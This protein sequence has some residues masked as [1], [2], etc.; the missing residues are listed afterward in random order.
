MATPAI[1]VEH[2]S[3]VFRVW[4]HP[5]DML[6]EMLTGRRR[7]Q[8]FEA[9]KD[10]S[11]EVGRGEIVGIMGRNGAG[12]STMLRIIAG[13]LDATH[14]KA[15]VVGRISAILELGTGFHGEY[16][17]R[18]NIQLGG[19][20]LGLSASEIAAKEAEIIAF[21]ELAEFIDRPFKTYSSGMQARLTFA[22]ATSID[23]DIFI[24]DEAL[25]V[26]D[27]KFQR[28]CFARFEDF[29]A[30]GRTILFVT[31]ATHLVEQICDRAI[32]LERG[33][34]KL[35]GSPKEVTDTYSQDLFGPPDGTGITALSS[36]ADATGPRYG[37]GGVE[38]FDI[39]LCDDEGRTIRVVPSGAWCIV[40]C[41]ARCHQGLVDDLNIGVSITTTEGV[42]LFAI[43]PQLNRQRTPAL[44]KDDVL[45]V[46]VRLQM[47]LGIGNYFITTGAWGFMQEHHYDRRVDVVHFRIS[48][49]S[50][51]SQ[52]LVNCFP[53][54]DMS[55][56]AN[57]E[58]V[59]G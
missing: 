42:R 46:T 44:R 25:S 55:L 36:Q 23:P 6:K 39:D 43:N 29:K 16:S 8:E 52:S 5:S 17:G 18:E 54:Y 53:Q 28:K 59:G 13:T 45:Q 2:L 19:L 41:R 22:V 56:R 27:A 24:V 34:V 15:E 37:T 4:P 48:G 10:V 20:C 33:S 35:I 58:N 1:K 51:L 38:L 31:H 57:A 3:K 11:F 9:L 47:N 40:R 14:G 12:K 30:R 49:P 26:G 21:S 32:Y 7:H 50:S